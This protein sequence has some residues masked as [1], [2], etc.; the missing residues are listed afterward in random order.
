[1]FCGTVYCVVLG[2]YVQDCTQGHSFEI[3]NFHDFSQFSQDNDFS[4]VCCEIY[5]FLHFFVVP[6]I[7]KKLTTP[8]PACGF[9]KMCEKCKKSLAQQS[10][11]LLPC[12]LTHFSGVDEFYYFS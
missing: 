10:H 5:E 9:Y 3:Y 11:A 4:A 6:I 8:E 12:C 2:T 1:M 7:K